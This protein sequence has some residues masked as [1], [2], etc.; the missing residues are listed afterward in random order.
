LF[1]GEGPGLA[2]EQGATGARQR[3]D[4][5][6]NS[7]LIWLTHFVETIHHH[8][9]QRVSGGAC[10]PDLPRPTFALRGAQS[11]FAGPAFRKRQKPEA[12]QDLSLQPGLDLFE[13]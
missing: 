11:V 3:R 8:V 2:D 1:N 7:H 12:S 9:E 10:F 5:I 13:P 4:Q 6:D